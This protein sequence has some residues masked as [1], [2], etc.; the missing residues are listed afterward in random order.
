M[1]SICLSPSFDFDF[2]KEVRF[3]QDENLMPDI[4]YFEHL[5]LKLPVSK[6]IFYHLPFSEITYEVYF[7][8]ENTTEYIHTKDG[9]KSISW[10]M[11]NNKQ[12]LIDTFLK[13]VGV[14]YF[15]DIPG[16][17]NESKELI[18]QME[19]FFNL[20]KGIFYSPYTYTL[21]RRGVHFFSYEV[22]FISENEFF[23][24]LHDYC[25]KTLKDK[26]QLNEI[27]GINESQAV[28]LKFIRNKLTENR[29]K[30]ITK[31]F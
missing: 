11:K 28:F 25:F 16:H 9:G 21:S 8:G 5:N 18:T 26:S 2:F 12:H 31:T 19:Q 20:F 27:K 14:V 4:F 29:L 13:E 30:F 6:E 24:C 23:L 1:M 22:G 10:E 3:N 15:G 17:R 7:D